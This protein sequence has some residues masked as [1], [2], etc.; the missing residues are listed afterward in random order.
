MAHSASESERSA[1][2]NSRQKNADQPEIEHSTSPTTQTFASTSA[3]LTSVFP[4]TSSGLPLLNSASC[5]TASSSMNPTL[6][7]LVQ[8]VGNPSSLVAMG[9]LS[10]KILMIPL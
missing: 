4:K 7:P 6:E 3:T 5:S 2:P 1:S 8:L 10:I 9:L